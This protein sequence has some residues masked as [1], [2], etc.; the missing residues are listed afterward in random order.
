L[1]GVAV[2]V[3]VLVG[4]FVGVL[5]GVDV[6]VGVLVAVLVAVLVGVGVK[7]G[8][9]VGVFVG[10]FVGVLVAV[11]AAVAV[12]VF[13]GVPVEV[14]VAVFVAVAVLVGVLVEVGVAVGASTVVLMV[15]ELFVSLPST[16][17]FSGSAVAVLL[18]EPS[19]ALVRKPW[20]V[21]VATAAGP[22]PKAPRSQS[23]VPPVVGP[24]MTQ[25]PRVVEKPVK[26]KFA[27]GVSIMRT[28]AA[29]AEPAFLTSM[30]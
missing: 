4:V 28:V 26:V 9:L 16:T 8:V 17:A 14:A 5:V 2:K 15:T 13:V 25:V 1:V 27:A 12:G 6:F 3:G 18:A 10:V 29:L 20:M 7:V 24:T 23:S 11:A 30:V 22:V 21:M 19:T